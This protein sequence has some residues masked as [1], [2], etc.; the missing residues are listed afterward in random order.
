MSDI[1][2]I[3]FLSVKINLLAAPLLALIVTS[4]VTVVVPD[5][6]LPV[7]SIDVEPVMSAAPATVPPLSRG[8]SIV[9]LRNVSASSRVTTTP[10]VGKVADELTPVPP[11]VVGRVPLVM[12]EADKLGM[13]TGDRVVP[14]VTRP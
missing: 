11:N 4:P 10:A 14:E 3:A 12:M 6:I 1:A 13:S 7:V 2:L 9:L 5:F 8:D